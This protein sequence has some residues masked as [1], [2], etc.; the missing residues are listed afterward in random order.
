MLRDYEA[1]LKAAADPNRARI[2]KMLEGGQLCVCQIVAALGLSESTISK[3]LSVL[4][5]AGLV[6]ERK[7]GRWVYCRLAE[8]AVNDCALPLLSLIAAWLTKD[9]TVLADARRIA[10]IRRIPLER[11]CSLGPERILAAKAASVSRGRRGEY[12]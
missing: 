1:V 11:L 5:A 3:H 6:E 2:L 4:R 7:E 12:A 8:S 10:R 9:A